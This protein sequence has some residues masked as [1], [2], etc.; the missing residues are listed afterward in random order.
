MWKLIEPARL[1]EVETATQEAFI[2]AAEK[3]AE[4]AAESVR[5]DLHEL[6]EN[7]LEKDGKLYYAFTEDE[8]AAW[9]KNAVL[10]VMTPEPGY[11]LPV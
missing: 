7:V 9:V 11:C 4:I 3:N 8:F 6:E 2:L 5:A 10:D 1:N